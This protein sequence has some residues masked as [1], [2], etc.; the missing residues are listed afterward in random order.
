MTKEEALVSIRQVSARRT[1]CEIHREIYECADTQMIKDLVL[2]AFICGKKMDKKLK[3]YN[4]NW[5]DCMFPEN[6]D[7]KEDGERRA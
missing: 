1:I 5:D 4:K 6:K 2:E 3:E 7:S